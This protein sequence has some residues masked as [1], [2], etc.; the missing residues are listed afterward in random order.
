MLAS[1]LSFFSTGLCSNG[2]RFHPSNGF[3]TST[4]KLLNVF[5]FSDRNRAILIIPRGVY[6]AVQNIGQT[7]AIMINLPTC[8]YDHDD[9][10]KYRLPIK[11]DLIP[12]DFDDS[13]GW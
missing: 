9:P 5:T 2:L 13:L 10:G 11:N 1:L 7:E 8:P 4:Y 6:H 12:F 3:A